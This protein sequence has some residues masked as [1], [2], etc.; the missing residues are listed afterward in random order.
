MVKA[1]KLAISPCP[2][3][4]YIF[5]AWTLGL[6]EGSGE[7]PVKATYMDIQELNEASSIGNYDV[8]K[9]SAAHWHKVRNNYQILTCGAALGDDCGPLLV[10]KKFHDVP[11]GNNW[12]VVLPGMETTAAYLFQYAFPYINRKQTLLFS[13][14]EEALLEGRFDTGVLIHESRFN[15]AEKGLHLLCDLGSYWTQKTGCPIPLG[16]IVIR[17]EL[18]ETLKTQV[19]NCILD[20]LIYADRSLD[21]IWPFIR[22]HAAEMDETVIMKHIRLYVNTYSKSLGERGI[23]AIES[24]FALQTGKKLESS[25]AFI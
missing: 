23:E 18:P 4:T 12:D 6:S 7:L 17:R 25:S 24:L 19:K 16:L 1:L 11:P 21:Q 22:E 9:I 5:G 13:N 3:D 14:I 2:N 20:S 8:I 15:Y 10:S